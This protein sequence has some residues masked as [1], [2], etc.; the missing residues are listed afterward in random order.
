MCCPIPAKDGA[1]PAGLME[2]Q[3]IYQYYS[4]VWS[5]IAAAA[6]VA[7]G[8]VGHLVSTF[9]PPAKRNLLLDDFLQA[10]SVA[11]VLIRLPA[12][13]QLS[14]GGL[15]VADGLA[16]GGQQAQGAARYMFPEVGTLG[17][18][19]AEWSSLA[20]ALSDMIKKYSSNM[21]NILTEI[22]GNATQ[23]LAF[24]ETGA[25]CNGSLAEMQITTDQILQGLMTFVIS[26]ALLA[27]GIMVT[28]SEGIPPYPSP[29]CADA[30]DIDD[31]G[32]CGN[33]WLDRRGGTN[34][35]YALN[36]Q[37]NPGK[38]WNLTSLFK[39]T[40]GDLLMKG[41]RTCNNANASPRVDLSGTTV[42]ITCLA[43]AQWC[44]Y[45]MNCKDTD[46]EFKNCPRQRDFFSMG[47]QSSDGSSYCYNLPKSYLG[48]LRE[49]TMNADPC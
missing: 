2:R 36:Q 1:K 12:V 6:P 13:A 35:S 47:Q 33:F 42:Q 15:R 8:Y 45:N 14:N 46:C 30:T 4:T 44:D 18:Q 20:D 40:T 34:V 38:T 19:V 24:A 3:R 25:F 27:N 41:S 9:N 32:I 37:T 29:G 39:W 49:G 11:F 5:A 22:N 17:S 43:N 28:S 48:T 7:Q 26:K 16:S 23:F 21:A 31:K 10:L